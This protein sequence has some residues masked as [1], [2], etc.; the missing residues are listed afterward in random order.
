M[1][2]ASAET[3]L[4]TVPMDLVCSTAT[5]GSLDISQSSAGSLFYT[6]WASSFA[7]SPGISVMIS[8]AWILFSYPIYTRHSLIHQ[9][10]WASTLCMFGTS[11]TSTCCRACCAN[12]A[13]P[14]NALGVSTLPCCLQHRHI[15]GGARRNRK[16]KRHWKEIENSRSCKK[17]K[18]IL[19]LLSLDYLKDLKWK[20]CHMELKLSSETYHRD[21]HP[22]ASFST[23]QR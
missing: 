9:E 16:E 2:E 23:Y 4:L 15:L 7:S 13:R 5:H 8:R 3:L 14:Q 10:A 1:V 12:M 21:C 20:G 22:R 11:G 6:P 18:V 19:N 17:T